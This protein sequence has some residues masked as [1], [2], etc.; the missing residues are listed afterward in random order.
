MA[1]ILIKNGR[2]FD[3]T[4]LICKDLFTENGIIAKIEPDINSDCDFV[5]DAKNKFVLPGLVDTHVHMSS[6]FP[7]SFSF[8]PELSPLPFGVTAACDVGSALG[9]DS[10]FDATVLD[11]T[12][13]GFLLTDKAGNTIQGTKGYKCLLTVLNGQVMYRH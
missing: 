4:A 12:D 1:R 2:I 10:A 3:G 8:S 9:D 5:Y 13:E 7:D 6:H 11:Y